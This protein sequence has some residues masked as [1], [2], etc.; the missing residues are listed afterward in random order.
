MIRKLSSFFALFLLFLLAGAAGPLAAGDLRFELGFGWT[1]VAPSLNSTYVNRYKPP[2]VPADLYVD[3]SVDQTVY[4]KGKTSMGFNGFFN[5]FF[6]EKIGLQILADYQRPGVGG[7]NPNYMGQAQFLDFNGD[8]VTYDIDSTWPNSAGD[9]AET[10]FSLNALARFP[11]A[12]NLAVSVS[13]GPT[14]FNFEG[15]VGYVGY[16]ELEVQLGEMD[17]TLT[18]MTYQTI[19]AFDPQ[20]NYGFNVGVEAAYDLMR[21]VILALDLRYYGAP[22]KDVQMHIVD[23]PIYPIP[24]AE[25]EQAI[26][27]GS[28]SVN[29]SYFRAGLA[30]RFVF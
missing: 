6:T 22:S 3:S 12:D 18:G 20:S 15:K 29:P 8:V 24:A 10:T 7:A 14:L 30:I 19:V 25:I 27:L 23:D 17:Y 16:T 11:V 5:L 13:A 9:L 28:I 26:G 21:H 1:L 4:F 2:L